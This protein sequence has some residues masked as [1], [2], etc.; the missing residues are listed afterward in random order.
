MRSL[1]P[2]G[3]FGTM[4]FNT[5]TEWHYIQPYDSKG[6]TTKRQAPWDLPRLMHLIGVR[7]LRLP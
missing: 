4:F 5:K 3:F 6:V 2:A 7:Y 1:Q